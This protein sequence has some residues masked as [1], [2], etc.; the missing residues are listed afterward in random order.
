MVVLKRNFSF[1]ILREVR[2]LILKL[3]IDRK[4]P[5]VPMQTKVALAHGQEGGV[6]ACPKKFPSSNLILNSFTTHQNF[7]RNAPLTFVYH[8]RLYLL[9][10][11]SIITSRLSKSWC[12][13]DY[14]LFYQ[15]IHKNILTIF[16]LGR[17]DETLVP[18]CLFR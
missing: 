7:N 9:L 12:K 2:K 8:S 6:D 5:T 17:W 16:L 4:L 18:S 1:G 13:I 14:T 3:I 10:F 15:N 11:S